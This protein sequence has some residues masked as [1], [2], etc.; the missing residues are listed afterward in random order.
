ME[1]FRGA[2]LALGEVR[3]TVARWWDL[4]QL[5]AR[6]AEF[7]DRQEPVRERVAAGGGSAPEQAFADYVRLLTD[8]RRLPYADPGLPL[9][10]LPADWN[11]ARAADLFAELRGRLDGPAHE[12]AR[13]L[14]D[15]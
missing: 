11:G 6:Y 10:L 5:H 9:D 1:L 7:L 14:I 3:D 8:W 13:R 2:H 12:H 15:T 4:D